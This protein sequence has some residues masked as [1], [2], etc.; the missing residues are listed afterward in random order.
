[1]TAIAA[2]F[3]VG[4]IVITGVFKGATVRV[5]RSP[6]RMLPQARR[7]IGLITAGSFSL[8]GEWAANRGCPMVT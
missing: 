7:V 1:M 2:I 8:M 3:S 6:A 5:I 4:C